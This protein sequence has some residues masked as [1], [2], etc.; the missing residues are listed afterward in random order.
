VQKSILLTPSPEPV[1]FKDFASKQLGAKRIRPL[2][3]QRRG[4]VSPGEAGAVVAVAGIALH[5]AARSRPPARARCRRRHARQHMHTQRQCAGRHPRRLISVPSAATL[6]R[7]FPSHAIIAAKRLPNTS[8]E[9]S[10]RDT[11]DC[12][13]RA[14]ALMLKRYGDKAL[15]QS[16]ARANELTAD[17]DTR[18][19][20][21]G[22]GHHRRC[23]A[24][25]HYTARA[26]ALIGPDQKRSDRGVRF[27]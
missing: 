18:A 21:P 6:A 19:P 25:Q 27:I 22:A 23:P 4:W 15:E 20:T 9:F 2:T 7:S 8:V 13:W 5:T 14:A 1:R 24:R 3:I 17:G 16:S 10:L 26:A 11:R 12:I